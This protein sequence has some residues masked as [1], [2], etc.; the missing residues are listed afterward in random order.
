MTEAFESW[1]SFDIDD[2]FPL[3][4]WIRERGAVHPVT[5][6]DGQDARATR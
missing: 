1:G 3:F 6:T 5:L 2:P 4:M